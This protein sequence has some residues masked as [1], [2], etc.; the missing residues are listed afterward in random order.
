ME[1]VLLVDK[2]QVGRYHGLTNNPGIV[3]EVHQ[4]AEV[5][6]LQSGCVLL[7]NGIDHLEERNHLL[8]LQCLH[9]QN[10]VSS[11]NSYFEFD[12]SDRLLIDNISR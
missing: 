8:H 5:T 6:D 4:V 10:I 1:P 11:S 3:R 2:I 9:S 12:N 7:C